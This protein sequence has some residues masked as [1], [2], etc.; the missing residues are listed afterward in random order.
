MKVAINVEFKSLAELLA[1][2]KRKQNLTHAQLAELLEVN[3]PQMMRWY[4]I[5]KTP[6]PL[7]V[8]KLTYT[9]LGYDAELI[10]ELA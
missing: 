4:L 1:F 2:H 8:A 3:S 6:I 7:R 9:K 10:L 5:S